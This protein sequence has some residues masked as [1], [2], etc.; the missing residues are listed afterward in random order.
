MRQNALNILLA[1]ASTTLITMSLMFHNV[2][3]F[4]CLEFPNIVCVRVC[5]I[6]H[7]AV[8]VFDVDVDCIE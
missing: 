5:A 1:F 3:N 7:G 6:V 8:S 2:R 4:C